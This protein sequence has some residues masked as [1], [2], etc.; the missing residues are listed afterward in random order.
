MQR[1]GLAA[2]MFSM[3]VLIVVLAC[4]P[5]PAASEG[6]EILKVTVGKPTK[7]SSVGY[8]NSSSLAVSRTGVVAAFYPRPEDGKEVFVWRIS[9]DGGQTWGQEAP[10]PQ[11]MGVGG[12]GC[13]GLREG[14][15]IKSNNHNIRLGHR[16]DLPLGGCMIRFSDDF[17][18]YEIDVVPVHIP[19]PQ[20]TRQEPSTPYTW[21]G[22]IFDK[23]KMVQLP[24]GDVLAPMYGRLKGDTNQRIL[25]SRSSD[26]GRSWHYYAT[27]A[28]QPEDPNPELPGQYVGFVE[29]SIALLPNGQM[30]CVMR[31]QFAHFA[32]QYRPMY[33]C[34][35]DDLGK[36]WTKPVPTKPHLMTIWPTLQVLD[37]GVVACIYGRPGFHVAFSTDNGHTW[38]DR[39]SF[40]HVPEPSVTGQVD[41]IKVGPNKLLAIGGVGSGGTQIFPV[42]VE[43]VKVSAAQVALTGRVTDQQGKPIA[44]AKVQ[45]SPNRYRADS[46]RE[47]TKLDPWKAGPRLVG[48]PKLGY[49]SI[50]RH[51]SYPTVETDRQG[52][53]RFESVRLGEMI[54]TVEAE[55]YTPQWRRVKVGPEL[56]SQSAEFSL[57]P[58]KAV[59]GRILDSSSKPV[60]GAS[61][62]LNKWHVYTDTEGFFDWSV[63]APLPEQVEIKVFKRYSGQYETLETT[64][65]FSQLESR[66]IILPRKR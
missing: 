44:G 30:L 62:V 7:L 15:V 65:P 14:G 41:G 9:T 32:A 33:V 29:P 54:L 21:A 57:Q 42:T 11:G 31:T 12:A 55:S 45:R 26:Q 51:N 17:Q 47:G 53:F 60:S 2:I 66:P 35:S 10:V 8:Q 24:N 56:E 58:G 64:L 16:D 20:L 22:P 5:K 46:W 1:K 52:R 49:R 36:T 37:N 27:I 6:T 13:I 59:R 18:S 34:W 28:Y 39:V 40:S 43:R 19:N 4:D 23:G 38:K 63:G 48:S 50:R 25:I 3:V 61:V